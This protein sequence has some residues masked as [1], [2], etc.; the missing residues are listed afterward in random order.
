M[1]V[2]FRAVIFAA[3]FIAFVLIY[4]PANLLSWS[5]IV[6]PSGSGWEQIGGL[7]V[8]TIGAVIAVWC[9]FTFVR[10]GKG[11]PAPF[12]PPR[13]LVV[14]GPYRFVRNPM[15]IG[16]GLALAGASLYYESLSL[17]AYAAVLLLMSHAFVVLYEEP[18][19]KRTFQQDYEAYCRRVRRWRPTW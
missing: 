6:R 12:D 5:G 3:L 1:F 13:G 11:T 2:L 15:Y 17:L 4:I 10:V 8:G 18:T 7:V 9:I 19:L 14:G 16:A